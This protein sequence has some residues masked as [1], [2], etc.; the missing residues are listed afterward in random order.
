MCYK[1]VHESSESKIVT[2]C[3][4]AADNQSDTR[5]SHAKLFMGCAH[6]SIVNVCG[7][8]GFEA[9]CSMDIF[10]LRAYQL[11]SVDCYMEL[12]SVCDSVPHMLTFNI[13]ILHT[14]LLLLAKY[15]LL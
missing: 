9:Y 6:Q 8:K 3:M 13:L 7:S 14:A 1:K 4:A 12:E 2:A 11:I 15:V 5:C 10:P